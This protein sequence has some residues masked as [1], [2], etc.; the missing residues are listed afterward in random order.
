MVTIFDIG[1]THYF[2]I[3]PF[4]TITG[5]TIA[6][7]SFTPSPF[8]AIIPLFFSISQTLLFYDS[9]W[10]TVAWIIPIIDAYFLRK[11]MFKPFF[12]VSTNLILMIFLY[13][14][15]LIIMKY[16]TKP[17]ELILAQLFCTF[18]IAIISSKSLSITNQ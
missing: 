8:L 1:I 11:Y 3:A 9:Y 7:V 14:C 13:Q 15:I 12:I 18:L 10:I 5:V 6:L 17:Y 16:A 4:F 2:L